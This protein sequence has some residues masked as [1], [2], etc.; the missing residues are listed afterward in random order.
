VLVHEVKAEEENEVGEE[1]KDEK[2][3]ERRAL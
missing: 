2:A 3:E 1:E